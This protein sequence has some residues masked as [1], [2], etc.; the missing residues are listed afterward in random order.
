MSALCSLGR[1]GA[2]TSTATNVAVGSF[3]S[4]E[5]QRI[6]YASVYQ[7]PLSRLYGSEQ[8]RYGY[9]RPDCIEQTA[10]VEDDFAFGF[11][12]SGDGRERYVHLLYRNVRN[13]SFQLLY[14][15]PA[16]EDSGG[17]EREIGQFEHPAACQHFEPALVQVDF[18]AGV[19]S[20]YQRSHRG[21]CHR[22]DAVAAVLQF[23]YCPDVGYS[24]CS[25][26]CEHQCHVAF[27]A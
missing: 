13:E 15:A 12:V 26:A 1:D 23:L 3:H 8:R 18:S 10:A 14:D 5:R 16:F 19:Y 9:G 20:A 22:T 27:H 4:V 2:L 24:A 6:G 21:S 25:A 17:G 7:K 11:Y